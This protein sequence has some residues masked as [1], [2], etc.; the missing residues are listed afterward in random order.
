MRW[1]WLLP[2]FSILL[3][4]GRKGTAPVALRSDWCF[5]R[6]FIES[7]LWIKMQLSRLLIQ[8]LRHGLTIQEKRKAEL[9][10]DVCKRNL[11]T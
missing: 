8:D 7:Y 3:L 2:R 1:C 9:S 11:Q 5:F 6:Q 10:F 4:P